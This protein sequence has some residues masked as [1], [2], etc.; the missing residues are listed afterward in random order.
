MRRRELLAVGA[1][2]ILGSTVSGQEVE[3][4][5]IID[6]H[7]HVWDPR[8]PEGITWPGEKNQCLY[9]PI[10]PTELQKSGKPLGVVGMI[11]A[12]ASP[13]IEDK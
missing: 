9:R 7:T 11:V 13:R 8:R 1:A 10:L 3:M 12:E 2:S 5:K 6:C 4:L